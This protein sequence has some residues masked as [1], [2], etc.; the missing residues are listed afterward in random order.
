MEQ[1]VVTL[2]TLSVKASDDLY[3]MV[4]NLN[5]VLKEE[6][7]MFGLSKDLEDEGQMIFTIYRS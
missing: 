2:S 5:R 7:L 1:Q 3:K 4:D 6:D